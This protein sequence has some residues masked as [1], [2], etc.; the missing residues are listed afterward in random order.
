MQ[1][2]VCVFSYWAILSA[3]KKVRGSL[4]NFAHGTWFEHLLICGVCMANGRSLGS[5][6]DVWDGKNV[7][8]ARK[9]CHAAWPW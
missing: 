6:M 3:G 2:L 1:S 8:F 9:L 5:G 4:K 7:D